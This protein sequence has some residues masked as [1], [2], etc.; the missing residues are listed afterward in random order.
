MKQ[1]ATIIIGFLHDFAAGC[2]GATLL[3]I[4][5]LDRSSF[6]PELAAALSGLKREFFYA[7]L[8]CAIVV[9]ASG[10]GRSFTYI[11]HVYGAEHEGRRRRLLVL[12]H[13][14]LLTVFGL[15]TWWQYLTVFP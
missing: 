15:G 2:W 14:V 12:K 9:M 11:N 6:S 3:A 8:C 5:W 4:W 7:G 13:V 10:A 1:L